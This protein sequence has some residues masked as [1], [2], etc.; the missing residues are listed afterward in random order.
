MRLR[1]AGVRDVRAGRVR[2]GGRVRVVDHHRLLVPVVHL[3]PH[4]ELL[5]R[6]EA[7]EGGGTFRVL[8]RDE[9]GRAVA[10]GRAGDDAAGL[11]RVV[12]AGVRDDLRLQ[13]AGYR[14]HDR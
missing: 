2:L 4:F 13:V 8:H 1:L 5:E 10:A 9:P 14:E 7:V 3:T 11:V 12:P 6:V